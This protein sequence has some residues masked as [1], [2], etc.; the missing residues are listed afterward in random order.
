M[1]KQFDLRT[2]FV[3]IGAFILAPFAMAQTTKT[4]TVPA[5]QLWTDTGITLVAGQTVNITASGSIY[6]GGRIPGWINATP[7]G[8][9]LPQCAV[10]KQSPFPAPDAACFSLIGEITQTGAPFEVGSS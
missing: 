10:G 6:V 5:A 2:L 7:N 4:V 1:S 9:P 8:Q 3:I